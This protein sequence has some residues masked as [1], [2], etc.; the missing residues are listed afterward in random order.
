MQ[1]LF[2]AMATQG[3]LGASFEELERYAAR[4]AELVMLEGNR[5]APQ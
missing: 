4:N 1:D 5:S 3:R 2:I